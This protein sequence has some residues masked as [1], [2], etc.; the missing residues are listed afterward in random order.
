MTWYLKGG[1]Y[2]DAK[3]KWGP[4]DNQKGGMWFKKKAKLFTDLSITEETFNT[5]QSGYVDKSSVTKEPGDLNTDWFFL[6]AEGMCLNGTLWWT[7]S[8]GYYWFS[9]PC[10]KVGTAYSLYFTDSAASVLH[11]RGKFGWCLWSV[12]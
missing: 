9:T 1:C 3:K 7:G 5:T 10:S 6:P 12:Q 11:S 8:G 2:W 4:D